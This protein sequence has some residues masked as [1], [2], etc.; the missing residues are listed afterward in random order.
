MHWFLSGSAFSQLVMGSSQKQGFLN[1]WNTK[2][3]NLALRRNTFNLE[4]QSTNRL[5]MFETDQWILNVLT[6][7]PCG[8][9]MKGFPVE[10]QGILNFTFK[11]IK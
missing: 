10:T 7:I 8:F 5:K 3:Q 6:P 1:T 9:C 2:G 11:K 4:F